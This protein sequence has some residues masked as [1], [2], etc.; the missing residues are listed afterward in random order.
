MRLIHYMIDVNGLMAD[1]CHF[2]YIIERK[3][4]AKKSREKNNKP[5]FLHKICIISNIENQKL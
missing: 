1:I 3:A 2:I 4:E 5:T